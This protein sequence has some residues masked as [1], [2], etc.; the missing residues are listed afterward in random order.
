MPSEPTRTLLRGGTVVSVDPALG[1]F[2]GDVLIE[3]DVIAAVGDLGDVPGAGVI[4]VR[5]HIVFPGFVDGHRHLYQT[6]LRGLGVEWSLVE[7]CIA[8]FGTVG[9]H[10]SAEDV[11]LGT[12]LGALDSIDAGVTG[13]YD[14]AHCQVTPEHTDRSLAALHESGLRTVFGYGGSSAQWLEC[15]APP[16]QSSTPMNN[17]E[18]RRLRNGPLSDDSA[19]VTLGLFG[20]GPDL[21][22]MDVVRAEWAL[23]KEL[24]IPTNLHVGQGIFPG[25]PALK[26]LNDEGML[27]PQVSIGH[28]NLLTD[29]EMAMMRDTGTTVTAT[30]EIEAVMGHGWSSINRLLAAGV[31]P[32]LG[33]DTT[34]VVG[35]DMFT[36]M[37]S[38]L[39]TARGLP[40]A[41][42]L[43]AG[44]NPMAVHP[45]P[46]DV[47]AF[48]TIEGARALG[49]ADV[50]GS[51][52]VGKKADIVTMTTNDISVFP[53]V[54]PVS[55]IV[56]GGS[57]R[58]VTNVFVDGRRRK[59]D[60]AL[61]G[62]DT[63]EL[64]EAADRAAHDLIERS[65]IGPSWRPS[66]A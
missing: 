33:I 47:L 8:V 25:R 54:D 53:V 14:L 61:V 44:E 21:G 27:G 9:A 65:G 16:F 6:V 12:L 29:E 57:R 45:H 10:L 42:R 22:V 36:A 63:A 2:R 15:L 18:V 40:N 19:L 51:I 23:A 49:K 52:T 39:V 7:Y 56:Y 11:Y 1:D 30:P 26:R 66:F 60:G 48:A 4:D 50:T 5:D 38:A 34:L 28:A 20:R 37:R 46:R 32:N 62:V 13:V 35:G 64:H 55:A 31:R 43:K 58:T 17:A 59:A 24:D 41:E 3:G